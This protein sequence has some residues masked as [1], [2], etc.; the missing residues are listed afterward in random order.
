MSRIAPAEGRSGQQTDGA[1]HAIQPVVDWEIVN[2]SI[3]V[4]LSA[5]AADVQ[6][7]WPYI[8]PRLDQTL[9]HLLLFSYCAFEVPSAPRIDPVIAGIDFARSQSGRGIVIRADLS[10]E[11]SGEVWLELP[12]REVAEVQDAICAAGEELARQLSTR[13]EEIHTALH[14]QDPVVCP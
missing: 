14:K 2:R 4:V 1:G 5:F 6:A 11:E 7:R 10:G 13:A 9:T 3:Q 8:K 12:P